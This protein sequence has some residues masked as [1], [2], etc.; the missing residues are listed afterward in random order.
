MFF[1][2]KAYFY[3]LSFLK[4]DLRERG[5]ERGKHRF[6]VPPTDALFIGRLLYMLWVG[7]E[8]TTL[9]CQIN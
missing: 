5:K 8:P 9:G 7:I 1:S 3:A 4:I 2:F 6:V